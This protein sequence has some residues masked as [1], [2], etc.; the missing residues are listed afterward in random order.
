VE[1]EVVFGIRFRIPGG[2]NEE[3]HPSKCRYPDK[4]TEVLA[5]VG[6]P[7]GAPTIE[8]NKEVIEM[9]KDIMYQDRVVISSL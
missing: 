1:V 9:T 5:E 7:E 4:K 8:I 2:R 3:C 6:T